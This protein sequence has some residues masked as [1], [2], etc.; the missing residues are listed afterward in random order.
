MLYNKMYKAVWA[1]VA[2]LILSGIINY[3]WGLI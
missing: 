1:G 2:L 3:L